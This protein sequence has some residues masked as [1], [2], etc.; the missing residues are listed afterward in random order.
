VDK[1]RILFK[2]QDITDLEIDKRAGLGIGIAEQRPPVIQ[3]LR[4][5][6]LMSYIHTFKNNSINTQTQV[7]S[8]AGMTDFMDRDINKDFSGGEIKRA[9]L[10]QLLALNPTFSMMDEPDSGVDIES[11]KN[12]GHLIN[13]L[14]KNHDLGCQSMKGAHKSGLIVTHYGNILDHI[15]VDKAHVMFMGQ[16]GCSGHPK[17]ILETIKNYGYEE[18]VSCIKRGNL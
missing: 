8:D 15:H 3:G 7:V 10:M 4:L 16:I 9:E 14:F 2:G 13:R 1:G 5:K 6:D 18:C 11:L 17:K 12:L